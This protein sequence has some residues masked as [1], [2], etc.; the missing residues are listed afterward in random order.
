MS[1]KAIYGFGGGAADGRAELKEL[2]GGKGAGLAEMARLGVPVPPGFTITTEVCAA[3][4]REHAIPAAVSSQIPAA[5][6]RLEEITGLRFGDPQ[7]PLLLSVRSGAR[8]SMPGMMDTVLDLGLNDETVRGLAARS[9]ERF[10]WD[11]YR[12][13][14]SMYGGVVLGLGDEPFDQIFDGV[15]HARH[16]ATDFD[17]AAA[18]LAEVV[19]KAKA[20]IL[21]RT[22]HP[23]PDDP[24]EQLLRAIEAVFH[25]WEN[26]RAVAYRGLHHIPGD[27]GTAVTVQA[28]VF[29]NLGDDSGTGVVFSRDPATGEN[30]LYGEFLQGAQGED[31]VAG[32]RTPL[33]IT[34]M[35]RKFPEAYRGLLE[36]VRNLEAHFRDMQDIEFTVERGRLWVLQCRSGKRTGTAAVR[37]AVEMVDEGLIDRR[38]AISRVEP[39]ALEQLLRP[40]FDGEVRAR[41]ELLARG[42]PAGPGAASGRAVFSAAE[43]EWSA[44][45]GERVILVREQT[46]PE[47]IRGMAAAEG[48]LTQ[49]GGMTSH[50]A[51]VAR[52]MGKV[53]V[54]GVESMKI[55]A[56]GAQ[57][58]ARRVRPGDWISLDGTAGEVVLGKLPTRESEALR[59]LLGADSSAPIVR[60]LSWADEIRR[61]GVRA[62]ADQGDQAATAAALGAEGIGLCRTE[63]MFFGPGKIGPMR[64]MI[65]ARTEPER[66]AALEKLLPL[67]RADFAAIFRAMAGRHVT[68]RTL[69][70]PLHEFLPHDEAGIAEVAKATGRTPEEVTARVDE[71]AESNPMLGLR[72]CRLGISYPEITEMQAVA[73][74]EAACD[75]AQEGI[76]VKPQVM[77]PL[78]T[79]REELDNQAKVV[80][81]AA[82]VV[83]S[84]RG[85]RVDWKFGAMIEVPRAALLAGEIAKVS[86]FVS[87]GT[88][89]L[90]QTV[91][92]LSRDDVGPVLAKYLQLGIYPHDPFVSMDPA[93]VG[94]LVRTGVERGRAVRPSLEVGICGEHGGDPASIALCHDLGLDYVSCSPSRLPVARLAAA[95]AA[96]FSQR[97][98]KP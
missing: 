46:S 44:G 93:G 2:L 6:A 63:H 1:D 57:F 76:A 71:L 11:C 9:G 81:A 32:I 75:V 97:G 85:R 78:A 29:G 77:I 62:N 19:H 86:E 25:S 58:G 72:G 7:A 95:R 82:E 26:P 89:D 41:S 79:S 84:R 20:L 51:L 54:V 27:W 98:A 31:V 37:L 3:F 45:R 38:T 16:A 91:Y 96:I 90:T 10:A 69:D 28:M 55:D 59:G 34:E 40:V 87:F 13:F 43:A 49:Y 39:P 74:F 53:A 4:Q 83:F 18:D 67:Q 92:G 94:E 48:L 60:L 17:L 35:E 66:R 64:E 56:E 65:L 30:L 24:R 14:V 47:D 68:I 42:L 52:Q 73:I 12:R 61:L 50:A 80:R 33:H 23:L 70:P 21:A 15:K 36:T 22:G 5:L 88:N 8:V